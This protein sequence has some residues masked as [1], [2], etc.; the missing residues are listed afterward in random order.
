MPDSETS[1]LLIDNLADL[2]AAIEVMSKLDEEIM[3]SFGRLTERWAKAE[4]WQCGIDHEG[5]DFY[6]APDHWRSGEDWRA[7]FAFELDESAGEDQ[8]YTTG[9]TGQ[10]KQSARFVL[11]QEVA[12]LPPWRKLLTQ[13]G[14]RLSGTALLVD[15]NSVWLPFTV[16]AVD[17]AKTLRDEGR[18]DKALKA[19][20]SVLDQLKAAVP[21][22][23]ELLQIAKEQG[24]PA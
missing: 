17:L 8:F 1:A 20:T 16:S 2:E 21:V 18:P 13:H 7:W 4:A 6:V 14:H 24:S 15:K 11:H 23:D 9:L 5:D 10:G 19:L 22:V 12:N 3:T